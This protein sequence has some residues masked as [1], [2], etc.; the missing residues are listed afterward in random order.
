MRAM[1]A[2]G[3]WAVVSTEETEIHP[4]SDLAPLRRAAHLG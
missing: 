4:T 2:E 1:K 3:G